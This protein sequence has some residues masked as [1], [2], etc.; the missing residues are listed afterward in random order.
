MV[1]IA[2]SLTSSVAL[3]AIMSIVP[4]W[5]RALEV[6]EELCKRETGAISYIFSL[7]ESRRCRICRENKFKPGSRDRSSRARVSLEKDHQ[8]SPN[9]RNCQARGEDGE[10][11]WLIFEW[12]LAFSIASRG[13][14][15]DKEGTRFH[16]M[17]FISES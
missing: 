5:P 13:P 7:I 17:E 12:S 6:E 8:S 15:R 3:V 14:G 10:S 4:S 1:W 16:F 11:D 9:A 2:P